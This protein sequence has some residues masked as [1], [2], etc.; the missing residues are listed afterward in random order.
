MVGSKSAGPF[1]PD[2]KAL[3]ITLSIAS[4]TAWAS[5]P[6]RLQT[7]S[8]SLWSEKMISIREISSRSV[9]SWLIKCFHVLHARNR[10]G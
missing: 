3:E 7:A 4:I 6:Q 9:I 1:F 10:S 5:S 8:I 2:E